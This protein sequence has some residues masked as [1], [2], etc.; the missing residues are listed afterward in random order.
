MWVIQEA[1]LAK[2]NQC[3]YGSF[4]FQ[5]TDVLRTAQWLYHKQEQLPTYS[6]ALEQL[7][8]DVVNAVILAEFCDPEFGWFKTMTSD[9]KPNGLL[10]T[11]LDN[12]ARFETRDERDR[13]F[14]LLGVHKHVNGFAHPDWLLRCD[15]GRSF[16]NV[17][18]DASLRSIREWNRLDALS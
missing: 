12:L 8:D 6:V 14:G 15:Y 2:L 1:T 3:F 7:N 5:W 18:R 17:F 10:F 11:L 16:Q 13:V 4:E 9:S